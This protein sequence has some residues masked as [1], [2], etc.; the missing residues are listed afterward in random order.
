MRSFITTALLALCTA[1]SADASAV[2]MVAMTPEV[3]EEY[4]FGQ[5][6]M[7]GCDTLEFSPQ[8]FAVR[9]TAWA[10]GAG[11]P[12]HGGVAMIDLINK[13]S[14]RVINSLMVENPL[15]SGARIKLIGRA[16][17]TSAGSCSDTE[18]LEGAPAP[19]LHYEDQESVIY[20]KKVAPPS[21]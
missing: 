21:Q 16:T 2:F 8:S 20:L 7:V 4:D 11:A 9:C 17:C 5:P 14:A 3:A 1:G 13:R 10:G 18:Y 12:A 15:L 19:P 6:A